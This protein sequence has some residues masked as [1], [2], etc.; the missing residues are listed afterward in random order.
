MKT[1]ANILR[2][3]LVTL[4][5]YFLYACAAPLLAVGNITAN[6][7]FATLAIILVSRSRME[8]F[9]ASCIMGILID[10]MLGNVPSLYLLGYPILILLFT[11]SFADK[12]DKQLEEARVRRTN[13]MR[14]PNW[15]TKLKNKLFRHRQVQENAPPLFR[16]LLCAAL[17]DGL[18]SLIVCVYIS[19]NGAQTTLISYLR[20]LAGMVYTFVATLVLYFPARL[21]LGVYR[22]KKKRKEENFA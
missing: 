15:W 10:T 1:I 22:K 16:A 11:R 7:A 18:L 13:Q 17:M 12:T 14:R 2:L 21:L 4:I 3:I 6:T 5:G 19:L 8:T 20:I 9:C